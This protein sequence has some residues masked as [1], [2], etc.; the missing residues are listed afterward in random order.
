MGQG[1][2]STNI[3]MQ[4]LTAQRFK[5]A[6]VVTIPLLLCGLLFRQAAH[7]PQTLHVNKPVYRLAYSPNGKYLAV[8]VGEHHPRPGT[9][10][11]EVVIYDAATLTPLKR[12][13]AHH[14]RV[15]ALTYS[16]DGKLLATKGLDFSIKL[17]DATTYSLVHSIPT[18]DVVQALAFSPD[19]QY[20]AGVTADSAPTLF[21]GKVSL[22][23]IQTRQLA[24][25]FV[26]K[27]IAVPPFNVAY[28]ADGKTL[29]V[30]GQDALKHI[31]VLY[32]LKTA[33]LGQGAGTRLPA[34]AQNLGYWWHAA[35]SPDGQWIAVQAGSTLQVRLIATG[36][37]LKTLK[38]LTRFAKSLAFSR[39]S[40]L[41]AAGDDKG[42]VYIWDVT[43]GKL[44]RQSQGHH[45]VINDIAF[46]PDA[47]TLAS[48]S[49][50]GT[51]KLWRIQ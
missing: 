15:L 30:I 35:Q 48:A 13:P 2:Y 39:D 19:S 20:L 24:G 38:G 41:L 10:G 27:D 31:T 47:Q 51:V 43:T 32:N 9:S 44:L 33:V 16:P 34:T 46:S 26:A 1:S 29:R 28:T 17:W 3:N 36:A 45:N 5:I 25:T 14:W 42:S 18:Q 4:C 22:W 21:T 49:D 23:H 6:L 7:L 12:I 11:G 8:G 40:R 50:D 37:V